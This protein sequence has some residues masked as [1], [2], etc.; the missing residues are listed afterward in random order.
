MEDFRTLLDSLGWARLAKIIKE[1]SDQKFNAYALKPLESM[2]A[3]FAEQ[4]QKGQLAT[5]AMV[6][7]LPEIEYKKSKE[8]LKHLL[9]FNPDIEK[10]ETNVKL[11]QP[12]AAP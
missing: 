6:L 8:D 10:G 12:R 2:D 9:E 5:L 7:L 11:V 1:Q 4:F 3:V